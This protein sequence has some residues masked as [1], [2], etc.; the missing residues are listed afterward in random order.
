MGYLLLALH[1]TSNRVGICLSLV[2]YQ[3]VIFYFYVFV[4]SDVDSNTFIII[5]I[6]FQDTNVCCLVAGGIVED[7]LERSL[8]IYIVI[9]CIT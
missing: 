1:V 2:D 5:K 7:K 6:T 8:G 4:S 3:F 9:Y